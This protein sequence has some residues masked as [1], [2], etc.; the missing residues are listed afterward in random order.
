MKAITLETTHITKTVYHFTEDLGVPLN[1]P[2]QMIQVPR[3][4]FIMGSSKTEEGSSKDEQPE[5]QVTVNSFFMARYPVTQEQWKAIAEWEDLRVAIKL[6]PDPSSFKDDY[7]EGEQQITRWQRPVENVSWQEAMEYCARLSKLTGKAYSLPTEAQWEYACRA[8]TITP[9]HFGETITT[10]LANYDGIGDEDQGWKGNYGQGPKG[11]YRQQTTPVDYFNAPNAFGLS[12]IHGNVW[13]WCL[14]PWHPNYEDAPCNGQVWDQG[15]ED[16]YDNITKNLDVLFK[17][18]RT[19][20]LR[21]GCWYS[22]P[23]YCR[24]ADRSFYN[25]DN[26]SYTIGFRVMCGTERG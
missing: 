12:D 3:G 18:D 5:H 20:V 2:L 6:Q 25:R 19:R 14:D 23:A 15:K 4:T 9:F 21:A 1:L 13:E 11:I 16:L 7:Q 24:S 10:D 8:G 17:D 26:H 22:I